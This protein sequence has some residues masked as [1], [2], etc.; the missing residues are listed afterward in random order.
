MNFSGLFLWAPD[1]CTFVHKILLV[2][3]FIERIYSCFYVHYCFTFYHTLDALPLVITKVHR[4]V[5]YIQWEA[6][7][8]VHINIAFYHLI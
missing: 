3:L 4:E 5:R 6:L 1:I 8:T 7:F 2:C